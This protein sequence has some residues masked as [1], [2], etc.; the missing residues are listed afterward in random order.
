[1]DGWGD[2]DRATEEIWRWGGGGVMGRRRAAEKVEKIERV[3]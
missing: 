3:V 1:M 2:G